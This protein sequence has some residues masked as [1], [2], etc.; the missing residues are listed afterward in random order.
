VAAI[1]FLLVCNVM[2]VFD[3]SRVNR[4]SDKKR[5]YIQSLATTG[6]ER[7]HCFNRT[8]DAMTTPTYAQTYVVHDS[9]FFE[10]VHQWLISDVAINCGWVFEHP[11]KDGV[12]VA[13]CHGEVR[14]VVILVDPQGAKSATVRNFLINYTAG[15]PQLF[16]IAPGLIQYFA[17]RINV[18]DPIFKAI[19][20]LANYP[21]VVE[22]API[23][24]MP[25]D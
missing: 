9:V 20:W 8:A 14:K 19:D 1:S 25:E 22:R 15:L 10:P 21:V 3:S 5:K 17:S 2:S 6:S 13:V 18:N 11:L 12:A 16:V 7:G 24:T 4:V 23:F